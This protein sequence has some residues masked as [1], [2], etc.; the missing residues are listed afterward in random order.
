VAVSEAFEWLCQQIEDATPLDRL[1]AR[2]TVR[3]A[4]K[5]AGLD[6]RT[7]SFVEVAVLLK[8]VLPLEL[9]R[10][11]IDDGEPIC[12]SLVSG[13]GDRGTR[14]TSHETPET[15]FSRLGSAGR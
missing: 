10:R 8:R 1:E 14:S 12:A 3:L 2:G 15:V 9:Q 5:D 7:V 11:G 13:I 6:A 4:L